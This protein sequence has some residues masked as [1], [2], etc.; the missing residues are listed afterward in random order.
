MSVNVFSTKVLIGDIV[1]TSLTEDETAILHSHLNRAKGLAASK[2]KEVLSF[3]S[4]FKTLSI[5]S[6]PKIEPATSRIAVKR[7]TDWA[8]PAS[9]I[10]DNEKSII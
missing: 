5:D 3:P 4:Y 6:A 10:T 9:V 2:A 7:S 1:C 8:N